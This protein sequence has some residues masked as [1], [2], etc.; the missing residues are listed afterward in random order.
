MNTY[1][2]ICASHWGNLGTTGCAWDVNQINGFILVPESKAYTMT[3]A[4]DALF[5]AALQ[6]DAIAAVK[7][8][9]IYPY[10][11]VIDCVDNT[12]ANAVKTTGYGIHQGT[13]LGKPT[14]QFTLAERGLPQLQSIFRFMGNN[15]LKM[16]LSDKRG[17]LW[18]QKTSTGTF[19]GASCDVAPEFK[20]PVGTDPSQKLMNVY[21]SDEEMFLNPDKLMYYKFDDGTVLKD[22]LSS[23]HNVTL[24]LVSASESDIVVKVQR[25]DNLVD[26]GLTNETALELPAAWLLILAST[27]ASV[28]ISTVT[29]SAT[30]GT[31]TLAGTFA[32]ALNYLSLV[33]PAALYAL[34]T[35]MG[36]GQTGGYESNVLSVTPA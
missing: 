17:Y 10:F 35:P 1:N 31:F 16:F 13:S 3:Y 9:R 14:L 4:T 8:A 6:A 23:V 7:S 2:N 34:A 29:Y 15:G 12:A 25:S 20:V 27:G 22:E 36:N 30:A 32:K 21:F 28:V 26:L 11:H 19:T 24:T 18:G 33:S 5:L